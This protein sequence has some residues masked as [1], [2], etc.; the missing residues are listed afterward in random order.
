M[1]RIA[2]VL[3]AHKEP[4]AVIAQARGL[5]AGGSAV[6]IHYDAR[7]PA[8]EFGRI[9]EGLAGETS[10]A[11]APRRLRCGWGEWSLVAATLETLRSALRAFPDATHVYLLSGDCAPV[12]SAAH[13]GALLDRENADF[14][15]SHDFFDS[16][17]IRTG[18]KAERLIYRHVFNERR[19]RRL[20]YGSL[21]V[22]ERLR[23]R[24]ALPQGL[25]AHIGSQW[26][27]LRRATAERVL[28]F[29][30]RRPDVVRFFRTTWIPDETFFQTLVRH[31]VPWDEI[32]N[33][34]L[35]FLLFTDYGMPATFYNDHYDLLVAQDALL[36]RKISSEATELQGRLRALW[37]DD[38]AEFHVSGEG[39]R[40][41]RFLTAQGRE[42]RR[43][44]PRFWEADA[45][46]ERHQELLL[47]ACKKWHV[48]RRLA[49]A[50]AAAGLMPAHGYVFDDRRAELPDLGGAERSLDKRTRHR[51]ALVHLLLAHHGTDRL[52]LCVDPERL[53]IMQDFD[54][55]HATVRVLE[56]QCA[57][58][59][60][61]LAG[62]ARRSGLAGE[63]TPPD[64]MA[65]LL[66]AVRRAIRHESDALATAGLTH[67]HRL[68]EGVGGAGVDGAVSLA[69]FLSIPEGEAEAL[70]QAARLFDD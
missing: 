35:T 58:N 23:L 26:W 21:A 56:I 8:A 46:L 54:A 12:K 69:G 42:G 14:I 47:V 11:Y 3:L 48:A 29:V 33:R 68:R 16:D 64:V 63:A 45:T 1:A 62:H 44:A 41:F 28:A 6:A 30:D 39:A 25:R 57:M 15:E 50:V 17:W 38:G 22:Q 32:R 24:R 65:G 55:A 49:G 2:F 7:A 67:L 19:A 20:F 5:L 66:P 37:A 36:A 60:D 4:E 10:V 51:R 34:S 53:D 9:R 40:L 13:A 52:L 43:F 18:L 59:D 61:W 70:L 31:L 27:C